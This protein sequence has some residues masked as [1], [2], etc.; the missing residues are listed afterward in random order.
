MAS[1]IYLQTS[2]FYLCV[3]TFRD[4]YVPFFFS[5]ETSELGHSRGICLLINNVPNLTVEEKKLSDL[6]EYLSFHVEVRKGLNMVEM[7]TV[8]QEFAEKDH[9]HF[10]MFA[11]VVMTISGQG[12]EIYCA[13]GRNACLEHVMMEYTAIRCPSLQAKPKLFFIHR[14]SG[15]SFVI[16]DPCSNQAHG[17]CVE[18][19]VE[20]FPYSSISAKDSCPG[21]ADFLLLCV[22]STSPADENIGVPE[23]MFVR[24]S[25]NR[26]K[27]TSLPGSK[28][29][30]E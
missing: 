9:S 25:I 4:V 17:S 15:I 16:N 5:T 11:V 7:Y 20:K 28:K 24:V 2:L 30:L 14:F 23:S 12:N 26:R 27:V 8:A 3:Y 29:L 21:E 6:F 22:E 13:D 10:D 19:D 18:N 1:Y